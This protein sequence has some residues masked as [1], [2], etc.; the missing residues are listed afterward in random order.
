M[1]STHID[2]SSEASGLHGP[3]GAL[4][5]A[6]TLLGGTLLWA[7]FGEAVYI[8]RLFGAIAGCF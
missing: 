7:S 5:L 8:E 1:T 6:L 2:S 4:A 3:I